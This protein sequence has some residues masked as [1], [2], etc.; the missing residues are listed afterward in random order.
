MSPMARPLRV[1]AAVSVLAQ[2][3]A[4]VREA[5]SRSLVDHASQ[6]STSPPGRRSTIRPD[7]FAASRH[8]RSSAVIRLDP[9][10]QE[11]LGKGP[12]QRDRR[13]QHREVFGFEGR[14]IGGEDRHVL[15]SQVLDGATA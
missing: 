1:V 5:L 9:T 15:A 3:Y 7:T 14:Q 10:G 6:P 8:S 4:A 12:Q 11:P 13:R 2:A